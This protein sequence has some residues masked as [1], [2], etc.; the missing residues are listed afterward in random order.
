MSGCAE[1][2]EN[3]EEL[4]DEV[5]AIHDEVMPLMGEIKSLRK[6]ILKVSEGLYQEDSVDNAEK[7]KSLQALA[8]KLDEAFDGMFVWMRQYQSSPEALS[9]QEY[10]EYLLDQKEKVE[11]VNSDIKTAMAEAKSV[12]SS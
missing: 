1:K 3:T 11:K 9:E 12:L 7:I 8:N 2:K 10:R 5:I 4:R 6:D